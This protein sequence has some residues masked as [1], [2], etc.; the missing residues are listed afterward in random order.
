MFH[1]TEK[2]RAQLEAAADAIAA[3]LANRDRLIRLASSEGGS[4]RE[5]AGIVRLSHTEVRRILNEA[6]EDPS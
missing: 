3:D 4:L 1:V 6:K 5:I 2:T